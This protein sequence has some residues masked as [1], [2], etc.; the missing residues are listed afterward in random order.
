[1][2]VCVCVFVSVCVYFLTHANSC[3]N[4]FYI[5]NKHTH[6]HTMQCAKNRHPIS[7][8]MR[9][10]ASA[11]HQHQ[12][13]HK[14]PAAHQPD[15]TENNL[16]YKIC[17]TAHL[18]THTHTHRH[19]SISFNF[20]VPRAHSTFEHARTPRTTTKIRQA[21]PHII[22]LHTAERRRLPQPD[23]HIA[24][25]G[26]TIYSSIYVIRAVLYVWR[27]CVHTSTWLLH[28]GPEP[29]PPLARIGP[30]RLCPH[31]TVRA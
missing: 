24:H 15:K 12:P 5:H 14:N 19:Q 3:M 1:M 21:K 10:G 20:Q 23:G 31:A 4:S 29:V 27:A 2:R 7:N 26:R 18:H 17:A 16:I 6:T 13:T 11:A 22:D 25:I 8:S 9:L 30:S 28:T